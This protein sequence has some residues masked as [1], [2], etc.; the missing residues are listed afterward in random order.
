MDIPPEFDLPQVQ[1]I[2]NA[3]KNICRDYP[4]GGSVLRELLQNA[5]DAQA[6]EVKFF[7]DENAYETEN[8]HPKLAQYQGPALLAYNNAEFKKEHFQSLSQVGNSLKM[9]DGST[10]GKFGRGFNSQPFPGTIIRLPLRTAEQ[11]KESGISDRKITVQEMAHVLNKFTE[12]FGKEGLLFM[13]HVLKLSVISTITGLIEIEVVNTEAVQV[14]KSRVNDA[15]INTL[16]N[17]F[18]DF[19]CSFEM[20]LRYKT[21]TTTTEMRFLLHH[22]IQG[23]SMSEE[24]RKWSIAQKSLPW[25]AV[26]VS[27]CAQNIPAINGSLFFGYAIAHSHKPAGSDSWLVQHLTRSST[28]LP[29][30][31]NQ[32]LFNSPIPRA[33][34]KLL[35][36]LA[37][38]P[39]PDP[40]FKYWP[41]KSDDPDNLS[42]DVLTQVLS[43]IG[44]Q[45]VWHTVNGYVGADYGLLAIG[46]EPQSLKLTLANAKIPVVYLPDKL[47]VEAKE[48]FS[49]LTLEPRTLCTYLRDKNDLV[50]SW[51]QATRQEILEYI[52]P[53]LGSSDLINSLA[54][55]PFED[56]T[57]RAIDDHLAFVHR[58]DFEAELF[59][60]DAKHNLDVKIFSW[61]TLNT[62][63]DRLRTSELHSHIR[64]RSARDLTKYAMTYFFNKLHVDA[65]VT[66]LDLDQT[67]FVTKTWKWIRRNSSVQNDSIA[68]LWL[69]PLANGKYRKVKPNNCWAII[70]PPGKLGDTIQKL[71]KDVAAQHTPVILSGR[72]GL[73]TVLV[74]SLKTTKTGSTLQ[75]RNGEMFHVVLEWLAKSHV[76][77]ENASDGDKTVIIEHIAGAIKGKLNQKYSNSDSLN[78]QHLQKLPIFQEL[79]CGNDEEFRYPWVRIETFKSQIG[80]IDK[81]FPLP[82]FK[83]YQFLDAQTIPIQEILSYQNLCVCKSK[84]ELLEDHII[85]AW[86]KPQKCTWSPSLKEQ[87]A[88]LMLQCYNDLSAQAQ[89]GMSSLPIVPTQCIDG[90]L[91]GRFS[92]ASALVDPENKWL[93]SVFFSDEEVLP[94]E[95]PHARYGHIFKKLGLRTDADESFIYERVCKFVSS[96]QLVDREEVHSCAK[97]LLK[98][99]C[100]WSPS[101]ATAAKYKQFLNRKWLPATFPDGTVDLFLGWD[102]ILHDDV[103]L[104]QLNHG[105]IIHDIEVVNAVLTYFKEK[106]RI[107]AVSESLKQLRSV[108]TENGIFVTASKGFFS[109]CAL[110]GPFLGNIDTGFAKMHEDILKAMNVRLR[111]GVKDILDVQ[112]QIERSGHPYKDSDIDILLETIKMGQFTNSRISQQTAQNLSIEKISERLKK[113]ELQLADD[114]DDDEDFQQCESVT[115]SISTTLDRYPIESTFKEYLA[116]ADDAKASAVNWMLDPRQHPTDHL[117]TEEM[118]DLQGPALLVHNDA[119]FRDIDFNGF[120]NVG[121]GSKREDK[122]AI[123]MFGRGSQTMFHFTDNPTLL[124]GDYLLILDPLQTCLPL[125][126][127]W[128]ARK[129]GVKILLSKLKQLH[130]NQLVPFH[131]LWG[132][133]TESDHYDGTIFRFP[134]RKHTSPLRPNQEP[135]G[136]SSVRLLLNQYFTQARISLLF[137]KGVKVVNFK[138]PGAKELF[139]S[140][141]RKKRNS[142]SDYTICFAKQMVGT[143]IF[144]TKDEWWVYSQIEETPSGEYQSRIRKNLEYGVAALVVS[145]SEQDTKTL[146]PPTPMLFS[147]LPLPEES[148]L[149]VHIHATFSL[150]GDR[151]TIITGGESSEAG[152]STWNSWL[153]EEKLPNAYLSFLEGLTEKI[154]LDA[155]RFWPPK[156]S[157]RL[158]LLCK[159]FW[160]QLPNSSARLFPRRAENPNA[161]NMT[162]SQTVFDFLQPKFSRQI[163]PVLQVLEPNISPHFPARMLAN[164]KSTAV[165]KSMDRPGLRKLLKSKRAGELLQKAMVDDGLLIRNVLNEVIPVGDVSSGELKELEGCRLLPLADGTLGQLTPIQ[166]PMPHNTRC[167]YVVTKSELKLFDFAKSIL[168]LKPEM[169]AY[170]RIGET[171]KTKLFNVMDLTI[172][173]IPELL[174]MKSQG[175]RVVNDETDKWLKS[176][177]GY[178]NKFTSSAADDLS[179][180]P[181]SFCSLPLFKATCNGA[182]EY[183]TM[184]ELDTLPAIIEPSEVSH[185]KLCSCISGLYRFRPEFMPKSTASYEKSLVSYKALG[186][187]INALKI[188]ESNESSIKKGLFTLLV[189]Q[190]QDLI[191]IFQELVIGYVRTGHKD[192][193]DYLPFLPIWPAYMPLSPSEKY[194]PALGA[195]YTKQPEL[196]AP[197]SK[198][199]PDFI[200][201]KAIDNYG[202][203]ACLEALT[204]HPIAAIELIRMFDKKDFPST[205]QK[206]TADTYVQFLKALTSTLGMEEQNSVLFKTLTSFPLAA[207]MT[208]KMHRAVELFDHNDEIFMAAFR[209]DKSKFLHDSGREFTWLWSKIGLRRRESNGCLKIDDYQ[210]CLLSLIKLMN[211]ENYGTLVD[212]S[213][214]IHKTMKTILSPLVTPSS[215][216]QQFRH[217]D[218]NRIAAMSVFLVRKDNTREP[219]YR[220]ENM[221]RISECDTT[222]PLSDL[223]LHEHAAICWSS[224]PFVVLEPTTEILSKVPRRG[225][226]S[227]GEVWNHLLHMVEISNNISPADIPDFLS[228]LWEIY[229][230]LQK[231]LARSKE[232]FQSYGPALNRANLWLNPEGVDANSI[233]LEDL[234]SSWKPINHLLLI[235][236][237]DAPPFECIRPCLSPYEKLLKELGC[238]SIHHPTIERSA[239][240]LAPPLISTLRAFRKNN[241]MIDIVLISENTRFSAHKVVLACASD[242]MKAALS[243]RWIHNGEITIEEMK[244]DVLKILIDTAYEEPINWDEM[245]VDQRQSLPAHNANDKKLNL[246]LDLHKGADYW[247]MPSLANE[248]EGRILDQSRFFIRLDNVVEYQ[249]KARDS[250]ARRLEEWCKLFCE[251]NA[252]ALRALEDAVTLEM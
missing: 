187:F 48:A 43:L 3:L 238:E 140:V 129:P 191:K 177:W 190:K 108:L 248:V 244:P 55:F 182:W 138:G 183:Y 210:E 82:T 167:Y 218:W 207:D 10:T 76:A 178:W 18:Q 126:S 160:E 61:Q 83:D 87:T 116:N 141:K 121:L 152:G 107:D 246:L 137:L 41:R 85:P 84:I 236:S 64:H 65:D 27:L 52:L 1:T 222:I 194:I 208:G 98:T 232:Y 227:S 89:A 192:A 179:K 127:N 67:T 195:K 17:S 240:Q 40:A 59:C 9:N 229:D 5:D 252:T 216:I 56:G 250:N 168:I 203:E 2:L 95:K 162:M 230:H 50:A 104:A 94:A 45:P 24:I 46:N 109:G 157:R 251:R 199:L 28:T 166:S 136:I 4:A 170:D 79:K 149:P 139:W 113:G 14:N 62:L 225:E 213:S 243:G 38:S 90:K 91:T 77:I 249:E 206:K 35:R 193:S 233:T 74:E 122:S 184:S 226:P 144:V 114:D 78:L 176:F 224:T 143:D 151:N 201:F 23:N 53:I 80:V 130:P 8:L 164:I 220:R 123:G 54:L 189:T 234:R 133:D 102:T 103:L 181:K 31:W 175:S 165:A 120:K 158:E 169:D 174:S 42:K 37:L 173:H 12:D 73:D 186:R 105:I 115:T 33:W 11:A 69:L 93:K 153:L 29:A 180:S 242:Y 21:P 197:W 148:T 142:T 81:M 34:T 171:V 97:S 51:P 22:S 161:T 70:P 134:L 6:S 146:D 96:S 117:L 30:Q 237:T 172:T 200:D 155:F 150:S 39:P 63:Q 185:Q 211:T 7:L 32:Y 196:L 247:L 132:Y 26:A 219:S 135:L 156:D 125:N 235:S 159:S 202:A 188:L 198:R 19:D 47:R 231:H 92:A 106:F 214:S 100:S 154:G 205:L 75:V 58:D 101:E 110:L 145:G 44:N 68:S 71:G 36:R 99:A 221:D 57:C 60:H 223:V 112:A 204:A 13:K 245:K 16:K 163:S 209:H 147:T 15:I 86:R 215:A 124:S 88:E 49:N 66:A 111:P 118:K 72:A 228:D 119:V 131:D 239:P 241:E 128:Q 25:V 217:T 212:R 20:E